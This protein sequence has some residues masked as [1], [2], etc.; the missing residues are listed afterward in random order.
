MERPSEQCARFSRQNSM[1][2]LSP[3]CEGIQFRQPALQR[4]VVLFQEKSGARGSGERIAL[5]GLD[6]KSVV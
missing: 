1:M 6:R 3:A 4:F 2:Q 5:R